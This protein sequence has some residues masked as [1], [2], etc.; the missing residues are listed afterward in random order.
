[1]HEVELFYSVSFFRALITLTHYQSC[2]FNGKVTINLMFS[3][4][5]I[6]QIAKTGTRACKAAMPTKT[7]DH[8]IS[9]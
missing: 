2:V 8:I 1:M 3:S 4:N 5:S 6:N 9:I 7:I